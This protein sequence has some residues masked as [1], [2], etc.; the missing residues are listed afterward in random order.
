MTL[1]RLLR[2]S[3]YASDSKSA[4][5]HYLWFNFKGL[6]PRISQRGVLSRCNFSVLD[7]DWSRTIARLNELWR[8]DASLLMD[9]NLWRFDGADRLDVLLLLHGQPIVLQDLLIVDHVG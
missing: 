5:G 2:V 9:L 8:N 7:R 6:S 1:V 3:N 4:V